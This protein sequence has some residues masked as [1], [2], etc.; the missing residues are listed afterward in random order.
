ML[1]KCFV[2]TGILIYMSGSWQ[3][4]TVVMVVNAVVVRLAE[5]EGVLTTV[6]SR[7]PG[8]IPVSGI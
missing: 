4:A 2:F 8:W 1:Y 6:F 3:H 7:P 5:S